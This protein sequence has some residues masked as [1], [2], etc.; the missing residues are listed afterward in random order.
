MAL[1]GDDRI[2]FG[3]PE[4]AKCIGITQRTVYRAIDV[5]D[6]RRTSLAAEMAGIAMLSETARRPRLCSRIE[7]RRRLIG[8]T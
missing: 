6:A 1:W 5:G 2:W 7:R 4:A 3:T 8:R